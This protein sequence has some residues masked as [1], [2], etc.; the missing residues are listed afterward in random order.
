MLNL[1]VMLFRLK[2]VSFQ[3]VSIWV[4]INASSVKAENFCH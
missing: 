4:T 1:H 3:D 2:Q